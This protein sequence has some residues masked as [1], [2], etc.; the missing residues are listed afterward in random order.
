MKRTYFGLTMCF[1]LAFLLV[2][3]ALLPA[4]FSP[5]LAFAGDLSELAGVWNYNTLSS[6]VHHRWSKGAITVQDDGAY[7]LAG[8]DSDGSIWNF[9]GTFTATPD[10]LVM[11]SPVGTNSLCHA[12]MGDTLLVCTQTDA[13]AATT[14]IVATKEAPDSYSQADLTGKWQFNRLS[15]GDKNEWLR[16][17][18]TIKADGTFVEKQIK[19]DGSQQTKTGTASISQSTGE[20][21]VSN[22]PLCNDNSRN[23]VMDS[24]KT[25]MADTSTKKDGTTTQLGVFTKVGAKYSKADLP[26]VWNLHFLE[27]GNTTDWSTATVTVGP[28]GSFTRVG[29]DSNGNQINDSGKLSISSA[30]VITCTTCN[31]SSLVMNMDSGKTSVAFT[32]TKGT[33]TYRMGVL[34]RNPLTISGAVQTSTG[35]PLEGVT[36]NLTGGSAL[37]STTTDS[38]GAFSFGGLLNGK[39]KVTASAIGYTVAPKSLTVTVQGADAP[40]QNFT[41]APVTISG[42]VLP[43]KGPNETL[44]QDNVTVNLNGAA[45]KSAVTD[46]NGN[47]VFSELP[48]G[49][50]TLAAEPPDHGG[51]PALVFTPVQAKI[52]I[53]GKSAKPLS[54]KYK[55][56]ASCKSCH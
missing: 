44:G 15:A 54:I 13:D 47:F 22:C 21:T 8:V 37:S 30:G 35:A 50:Y 2:G 55:T 27:S 5:A 23:I 17:N 29:H 7:D 19:S 45:V 31:K 3:S 26:G 20:V 52:N 41:G 9:S 32:E 38:A 25:V 56:N 39:Y 36:V 53:T 4:A 43:Y 6:G 48:N 28:D 40:N 1:A 24:G 10:G 46:Q 11:N 12:D 16:S 14:L 34:V 18:V 42:K 51:N 49:V 33:G